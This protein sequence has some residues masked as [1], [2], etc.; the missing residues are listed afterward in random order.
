M[1]PVK[2]RVYVL[3]TLLIPLLAGC[4]LIWR[5]TTRPFSLSCALEDGS[6]KTIR[7]DPR[8][9]Q[10]QELDP[11]TGEVRD[12]I[13][14]NEPPEELGGG[15]IDES[16]VTVS[17]QAIHWSER[18]YRPQFVSE[19]HTIDLQTLGYRGE[20]AIGSD[21]GA[22]VDAQSMTGR[23]RRVESLP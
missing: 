8:L 21:Y 1:T 7:V 16:T 3:L 4:G 20:L 5:W 18:M 22:E 12:T 9:Q 17:E 14:T 2:K 15:I 23:C 13:T 6:E 19:S 11:G 10:V